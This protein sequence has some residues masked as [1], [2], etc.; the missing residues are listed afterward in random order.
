MSP[1][2]GDNTRR[3][4]KPYM[5]LPILMSEKQAGVQVYLSGVCVIGVD[6]LLMLT[7]FT[8]TGKRTVVIQSC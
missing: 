6:V 3:A 7:S 2:F 5:L 1:H 4:G 8:T